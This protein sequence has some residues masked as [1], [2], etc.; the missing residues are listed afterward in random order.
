VL[1]DRSVDEP[2]TFT[3]NLLRARFRSVG[4][5]ERRVGEQELDRSDDPSRSEDEEDETEE[6]LPL[7]LPEI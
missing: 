5:G 2:K 7:R 1:A 4:E 3:I 6:I